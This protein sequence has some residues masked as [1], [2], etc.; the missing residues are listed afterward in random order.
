MQ[1]KDFLYF[2]VDEVGRSLYVENGTVQRSAVPK[3]L[4]ETP[5]GWTEIQIDNIRNQKYFALDRSF[6]VPLDFVR[7]GAFILKDAYYKT[8]LEA[9][10]FLVIS[11]QRLEYDGTEYGYV[12]DGYYR[13]EIDFSTFNDSGSKVTCNIM[14][15]GAVKYVKANENVVYEFDVEVPEAKIVKMDGV[16]LQQSASYEVM[17]GAQPSNQGAHVVELFL[18]GTEEVS[19]IGAKST[20]RKNVASI[21]DIFNS[22]SNFLT[23]S[24]TPTELKLTWDFGVTLSLSGVGAIFNTRFFFQLRLYDQAGNP[25]NVI[26]DPT[27]PPVAYNLVNF[28]PGDP[29]LLYTHH[30]FTGTQTF[31]IPPNTLC[32]L[33]GRVSQNEDFTTFIYDDV[34]N[35]FKAEYTYLHPTSYVQALPPSY[36]FGKLIEKVTEG[37]YTAAS[38]TLVANDD[39]VVTCGDAIRGL[40]GAKIKT[41][42]SAFFQSYNVELMLGMGQVLGVIRL[43]TKPY[44]IDYNNSIALGEVSKLVVKP[45]T[46]LVVN[47]VKV[48]Y[49]P[50]EY[51]DVNGRQEF[52]NTI[53][54][55]V[56]ITRVNKELDL[57]STY[58]ADCYGIEL[59]RINLD[60]KSTT[61]DSADNDVFMV[62]VKDEPIIENLAYVYELDRDLNPFATGLLQPETVFNIFLS[63]RRCLDRNGAYVRSLFYKMDGSKLT[64]QTTDKNRELATTTPVVIEKADVPIVS[65]AAPLFTANILEFECPAP[66]NLVE[67]LAASPVRAFSLTYQGI[68]FKGIA[69]KAGI[70]PAD[71]EA[72][73]Y[74]LLSAPDND[75]ELLIPLTD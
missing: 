70:R 73:T 4:P 5:D 47:S 68:T 49:Q 52:N 42:L 66:V 30:R 74:Q 45:A 60:G 41:S 18:V 9:K 40:P 69:L 62:H 38:D 37:K 29:L 11:K 71:Y 2:L 25:V 43:E 26:G 50:N 75:L 7:D 10:V 67:A 51:E 28:N 20:T 61:D 57:V 46:D 33:T 16:V 35:P 8:G 65:L 48:G 1:G 63:P 54:Y 56:P 17:N 6:T 36:L 58:R 39:I 13:G 32:F 14:E 55:T 44:W 23:T 59:T 3:P 31:N 64:F 22:G 24:S 53:Q 12:Y 72:Q 34:S 21:A 19:S 27:P 15:G